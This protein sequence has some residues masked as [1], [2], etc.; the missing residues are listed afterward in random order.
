MLC[1]VGELREVIGMRSIVGER[2]GR[3]RDSEGAFVG[4]EAGYSGDVIVCLRELSV[5][6]RR[7]GRAR[8][9]GET[10]S[11]GDSCGIS[12]GRGDGEDGPRQGK[13][14]DCSQRSKS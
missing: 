13:M 11:I 9:C 6:D 7:S 4:D 2:V 3:S 8:D 5:F 14:M 10:R 12:A 1:A